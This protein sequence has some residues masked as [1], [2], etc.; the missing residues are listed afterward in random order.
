MDDSTHP[1]KT[2]TRLSRLLGWTLPVLL[3]AIGFTVFNAL[4][5]AKPKPPAKAIEEKVWTVRT[6]TA[7]LTNHQPV[8]TL[9]GRVESPRMTR[10]TAAV[11]A[12][13]ERVNFDEGQSV[14]TGELL[15]KLD[16]R[17]AELLLHQREAD[18]AAIKAQIEA[19]KV[20][21]Q[22]D[23]RALSIETELLA[24]SARA[25]DRFENLA[26]RKVGSEDQLDNARR[27]YQ[28]QALALNS[29]RQA[30]NDH[31]NRLAQLEANYQRVAAQLNSAQLDL[32]RTRILAPFDGRI[33]R[34]QTSPGDRV[35]SGDPL[36]SLY[37][38]QRL[39]IRAQI[40]NRYLDTIRQALSQPQQLSATAQLETARVSLHLD[41]LAGEV[42]GGRAGI[43]ALFKVTG[44]SRLEPGRA[45]QLQLQLPSLKQ[46][47]A[48]PP[49]ALY[50]LDRI[51]R[52][53]DGRLDALQVERVGNLTGDDGEPYVL[54]SSPQ[55]RNGDTIVTTQ[56]PNA[57]S[58]LKVKEA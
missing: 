37:N 14:A 23:Q 30:L 27:T 13:V 18:L 22:A 15:I 55:L 43:D 32:S 10:L 47:A 7:N 41:R 49:Q 42:G 44:E 12:F 38:P 25:V 21:H 33:T 56:L 24:L 57:I 6:V 9:Y 8:L 28:Q 2:R 16:D 31:P 45:L 26:K 35:R 39:E 1:P 5:A 4:K 51:Y 52:V 17:D 40:P 58:G 19:E 34:L 29:R 36:I 20:R 11:T 3:L 50:G 46:V 48:L 54:V 53:T